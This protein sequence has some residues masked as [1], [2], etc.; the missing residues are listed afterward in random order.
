M[1]VAR[2]LSVVRI[3]VVNFVKPL[4]ECETG[5][6]DADVME[7][8]ARRDSGQ[9]FAVDAPDLP[10]ASESKAMEAL[11][12]LESHKNAEEDFNP[13]DDDYDW[14]LCVHR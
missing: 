11:A 6:Q 13:E 10:P 5:V 4:C 1:P 2:G 9:E 12:A 8:L 3:T 14:L 7:N